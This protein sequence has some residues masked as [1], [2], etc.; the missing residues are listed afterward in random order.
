VTSLTFEGDL[1]EV[2]NWYP[3][4][5]AQIRVMK[6]SGTRSSTVMPSSGVT[7]L[8]KT[9]PDHIHIIAGGNLF[10]GVRSDDFKPRILK[11][12]VHGG[13][14]Y[15]IGV[16]RH[17][18]LHPDSALT[19]W[20]LDLQIVRQVLIQLIPNG[21]LW[22][23]E[24][25]TFSVEPTI[26]AFAVDKTGDLI[27][28]GKSDRT[29]NNAPLTPYT[30][31]LDGV[32]IKFDTDLNQL[33]GRRFFMNQSEVIF[34]FDPFV[35]RVEFETVL[36]DGSNHYYV[37]GLVAADQLNSI[38]GG[39]S[40]VRGLLVKMDSDFVVLS[41]HSHDE[42]ITYQ[43]MTLVGGSLYTVGKGDSDAATRYSMTRWDTQTLQETT[44]G[45][46]H[47]VVNELYSEHFLDA[48][49]HS[50]THLYGLGLRQY[51]INTVTSNVGVRLLLYKFSLDMDLLIVKEL[52]PF[53]ISNQLFGSLPEIVYD[54]QTDTLFVASNH[55]T[56]TDAL[57]DQ[58]VLGSYAANALI[59]QLSP[60]LELLNHNGFDS[61]FSC[62]FTGVHVDN[63]R[64]F[65][66]GTVRAED[67]VFSVNFPDFIIGGDD[68]GT[69]TRWDKKLLGS[70]LVPNTHEGLVMTP[71]KDSSLVLVGYPDLVKQTSQNN[72]KQTNFLN[73]ID[74]M[75]NVLDETAT[76][77]DRLRP[78]GGLFN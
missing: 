39:G 16:F 18:G 71:T 25:T 12:L 6:V 73:T 43:S 37:G 34:G 8:M 74:T 5:E 42:F 28:C 33:Q 2:T 63:D 7:I 76:A 26:R 11:G 14:Y 77:R 17:V 45:L 3:F 66:A 24:S 22:P 44:I 51:E 29:I 31:I 54:D 70:G 53:T 68:V 52:Q 67:L 57:P 10:Y 41:E 47:R 1:A 36:V 30:N 13:F 23:L 58:T 46:N 4:A 78:Q 59:M 50:P 65:I 27:L 15:T 55:G 62:F 38:P 19:K 49:T 72:A 48:V 21:N 40:T 56:N 75:F 9:D 61:G 60:D 20:T 35:T 69:V 32:M 64:L